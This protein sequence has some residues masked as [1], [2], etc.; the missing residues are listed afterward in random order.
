MYRRKYGKHKKRVIALII[1]LFLIAVG[2][3][4]T[5]YF[6]TSKTKIVQAVVIGEKSNFS[7]KTI[8]LAEEVKPVEAELIKG[9]NVISLGDKFTFD[10]EEIQNMLNGS[11]KQ[12]DGKKIAFLTFDDGPSTTVTP[13]ILETLKES[14][15]KATFFIVGSSL[16]KSE[17]AKEILKREYAEGHAIGNHTY[18]H[19][20]DILYP[21][22]TINVQSFMNDIEKNQEIIK[23]IL[24]D[25]FHTRVIR[26][27][28]GHMSWK[29]TNE[30]D[31]VLKEKN[32]N[33]IDW[34]AFNGDAQGTNKKD[35]D[36]LV[37]NL[38]KTANGKD[39]LIVLMHDTYGKESTAQALP[40]IIKYLKEQGY[41]FKT[42]K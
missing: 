15:V 9:I 42:L 21:K 5:Q 7:E 12:K 27:P 25:E 2:I 3:K 30:I 19:R 40:E 18:S 8:S 26:F 34:N 28:G 11:E 10:A 14:N 41:D 20:Y 32:Y 22:S 39:K 29:G 13:Q 37:K 36:K 6:I 16:E 31:K 4:T 23:T 17:K 33:Y 1:L 24:G 38:I 35:K